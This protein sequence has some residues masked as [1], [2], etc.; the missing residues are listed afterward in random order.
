MF[1]YQEFDEVFAFDPG[2]SYDDK[3]VAE[4]IEN[5]KALEGLFIDRIM[6]ML[7]I[8]RRRLLPRVAH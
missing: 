7:G 1:N 2:C 4:I 3:T 8:V 6:K 5:R